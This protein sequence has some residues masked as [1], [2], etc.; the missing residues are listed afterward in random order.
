[1]GGSEQT[2]QDAGDDGMAATGRAMA[3]SGRAGGAVTG[4]A[5][6][7]RSGAGL[8]LPGGGKARVGVS[9]CGIRHAQPSCRVPPGPGAACP[10]P[11]GR[12]GGR[13]VRYPADAA[14]RQAGWRGD[15][16][17]S[18][19]TARDGRRAGARRARQGG[20]EAAAGG[21]GH[22]GRGEGGGGSAGPRPGH[23]RAWWGVRGGCE[24]G[25][26][27]GRG[28]FEG[29][30]F[31]ADRAGRHPGRPEGRGPE[32]SHGPTSHATPARDAAP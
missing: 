29:G 8:R 30:A 23:G 21:G 17:G 6:V 22:A 20:A 5:E 1:M 25:A 14:P 27:G 11:A 28:G 10:S 3:S 31:Q 24:G 32:A 15:A 4:C 13:E 16:S 19:E 18:A 26:W 9:L 7:T 2:R 12:E